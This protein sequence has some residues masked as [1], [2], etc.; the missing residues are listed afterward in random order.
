[1]SSIEKWRGVLGVK[2]DATL[3]EIRSA[4]LTKVRLNPPDLAPDRFREIHEAYEVL[5]DPLKQANAL[6][7]CCMEQPNLLAVIDEAAKVLPRS[8]PRRCLPS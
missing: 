3:D 1:M 5:R 2:L 4:Y 6:L 7:E 8:H